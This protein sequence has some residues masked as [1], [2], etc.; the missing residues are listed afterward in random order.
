MLTAL[1]SLPEDVGL[2]GTGTPPKSPGCSDKDSGRHAASA[3]QD[4]HQH[5]QEQQQPKPKQKGGFRQFKHLRATA[6]SKLASHC[7]ICSLSPILHV[8]IAGSGASDGTWRSRLRRF[9]R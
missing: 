1:D 7:G 9:W 5:E 2:E 6:C 3:E 4:E 8:Q